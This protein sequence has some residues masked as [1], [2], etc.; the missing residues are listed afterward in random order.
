[1]NMF[2]LNGNHLDEWLY[3]E[4]GHRIND[5]RRMNNQQFVVT[6]LNEKNETLV[7]VYSDDFK[8]NLYSF[9]TGEEVFQT[10]H[11]DI[12]KQVIR[13]YPGYILPV[14]DSTMIYAPAA[15]NGRLL[16]YK[17]ISPAK[18]VQ[19]G[20]VYGYDQ[21]ENPLILHFSAV[22]HDKRSQLS[23][24]NP[25]GGYFHAEFISMSRGL[26]KLENRNLIVHMS[27]R[28]NENDQWDLIIEY[29]DPGKLKLEDFTTVKNLIPS[30]QLQR[31]P[32]WMDQKG[33]VYMSQNSDEPMRILN[34][35]SE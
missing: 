2:S 35:A 34:I 24:F 3:N 33:R 19:N 1:M 25:K 29:F 8:K 18:W 17:K 28:L 21:I 9:V 5:I 16:K 15:Y 32:I 11:P 4:S 30:Q 10:E 27:I 22:G 6:G 14:S 31:I 23:G 12:E 26:Y 20:V 13:S 7:H